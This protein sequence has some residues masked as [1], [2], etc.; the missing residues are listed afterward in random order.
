MLRC[1]DERERTAAISPRCRAV[2]FSHY[3]R[4]FMFTLFHAFTMITLSVSRHTVTASH[5]HQVTKERVA[6]M[7]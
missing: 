2:D 1:H 3:R 6:T 4:T 7:F 5:L